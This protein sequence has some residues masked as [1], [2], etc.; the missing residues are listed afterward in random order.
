MIVTQLCQSGVN[1]VQKLGHI[2]FQGVSK[3][4][5][6]CVRVLLELCH[7]YVNAFQSCLVTSPKN[8]QPLFKLR[9]TAYDDWV[10]VC[11][12]CVWQCFIQDWSL[13]LQPNLND[14]FNICEKVPILEIAP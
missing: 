9:S 1:T 4:C 10:R 13:A 8:M 11:P 5:Q 3:L 2:C 7:N 12:V 14:I 6:S